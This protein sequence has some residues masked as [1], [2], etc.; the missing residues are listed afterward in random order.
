MLTP[1]NQ[2]ICDHCGQVIEKPEE[3]FVEWETR[4]DSSGIF[5]QSG[6]K[7][8]HHYAYS[9]KKDS[10]DSG[11]YHHDKSEFRSDN[12]LEYFLGEGKM[13]QLFYFLDF[14][15]PFSADI[16]TKVKDMREYV[17]FVKRLTIPYY[18]EARK[19]MAQAEQ[20]GLYSD[21]SPTSL[22]TPSKLKSI[23]QE[24]SQY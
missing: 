23:V 9:P 2:F 24:Y 11:C 3:G 15:E 5:I 17:D 22:Y 13:A 7:I 18:E 4:R 8:V 14:G 21:C 6:F 10:S 12:H 20:D 1:L 19:Y 16:R